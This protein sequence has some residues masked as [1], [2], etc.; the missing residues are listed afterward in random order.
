[1]KFRI[2]DTKAKEQFAKAGI[3]L[4]TETVKVNDFP[5][6]YAKTGNDSLPTLLFIHGSPGSWNAFEAY[7]RDSQ[8]LRQFR[9]IS[10]DRPGFGYSEFGH[11]KNLVDQSN[12]I[13]PV[14]ALLKNDQPVYGIGHSLGG[15]MALK[16]QIDNPG[17]FSGIVLLAAS[18]DPAE[19][20]PEKWRRWLYGTPLNLLV[21]G[22]FAP[23]NKELWFLKKDLVYLKK[24]LTKV[25]CP[26]W[27]IHG[28]KDQ[29][30]PVGNVNYIRQELTNADSIHVKI[31]H[32]AN[33]F[34]PWAP[35]YNEIKSVLME[36]PSIGR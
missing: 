16:L 15:P 27:I 20:K 30:V 2:S 4:H 10:I 5:I 25:T 3:P 11:S 33:H 26:I 24:D 32:G 29:F 1:M 17:Y 34:I 13:S 31:L 6:H 18:V 7:M 23:S 21:P 19:E 36:L 12:L 9:L 22:A 14:L 35:W 28:D 8:L